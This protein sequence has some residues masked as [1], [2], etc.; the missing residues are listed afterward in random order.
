LKSLLA[1]TNANIL[2][3]CRSL[4]E[5]TTIQAHNLTQPFSH[6]VDI[7]EAFDLE[8]LGGLEELGQLVLADVHLAGVHELED[9]LQVAVRHVLEDDD[10]VLGRVL[11]QQSLEEGGAGGEHHLVRLARLAVAG[12]RH[13]QEVLL[14]AEVLEGGDHVG[15]EV[16]PS[17]AVLLASCHRD[18][19]MLFTRR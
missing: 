17:Q 16:V 12:E 1:P 3:D 9:G 19:W 11:L 13:I 4:S 15:L 6:L 2:T 18:F 5:T 14:G 8:F 10:R 7:D